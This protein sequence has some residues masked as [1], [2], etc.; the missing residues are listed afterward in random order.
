L[1]KFFKYLSYLTRIKYL[2]LVGGQRVQSL[3]KSRLGIMISS[4]EHIGAQG[5]GM[6]II[7]SIQASGDKVQGLVDAIPVFRI[8]ILDKTII[9]SL[10]LDVLPGTYHIL[11]QSQ[12]HK[13]SQTDAIVAKSL[14][15]I[16]TLL[17]ATIS[18]LDTS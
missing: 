11:H 7:G 5:H 6:Q 4:R 13:G 8:E 16:A 9:T 2:T 17:E 10:S 18:R 1:K 12:C 15:D 14:E 3:K